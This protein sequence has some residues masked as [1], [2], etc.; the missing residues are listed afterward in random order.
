MLSRQIR[1][2][3]HSCTFLAGWNSKYAEG[4]S[5]LDHLERAA[6]CLASAI[7][8]KKNN[9]AF[10]LQLGLVLEE[11]YYAEDIVGLK[12]PVGLTLRLIVRNFCVVFYSGLLSDNQC[13]C[14]HFT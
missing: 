11:K 6:E 4:E 7:T 3:S 8:V 9:A 2:S 1:L 13:I 5:P 14:W 12:K 10:H